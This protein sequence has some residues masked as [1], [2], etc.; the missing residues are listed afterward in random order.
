[1]APPSA[2]MRPWFCRNSSGPDLHGE[3]GGLEGKPGPTR[4]VQGGATARNCR[5]ARNLTRLVVVYRSRRGGPP[6]GRG[7]RGDGAAFFEAQTFGRDLRG[8]RTPRRREVG[9]TAAG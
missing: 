4:R 8:W 1:M 6:H 9:T 7:W 3:L 5:L 2:T